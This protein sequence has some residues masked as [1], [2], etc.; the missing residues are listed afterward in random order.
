MKRSTHEVEEKIQELLSD[1]YKQRIATLN[2]LKL[3]SAL[4]RKNPYLFKSI[5]LNEASELVELMLA[6]YMS[7]SDE[8]IFGNVFFEPLARFVGVGD[9][10]PCEGVDIARQDGDIYTAIAV[11][12]GPNVFNAQSRKRQIDDFNSL[13]NRLRKVYKHVD[14]VVGY[15]YGRKGTRKNSNKAFRELAGQAFWAEITGDPE[16]YLKIIKLMKDFPLQH[17]PEYKEA[18][19]RALNRFTGEFIAE[20]CDNKGAILW[21][22]I[23]EF[24]SSSTP[25]KERTARKKRS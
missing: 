24:N 22:K 14:P 21:E 11:K 15:C 16:F 19:A 18:W 25:S 1:F 9:V 17:L 5:G 4:K 23:V 12:S 10:A 7:S 13:K 2:G 8:G 3:K 6:A 20:F